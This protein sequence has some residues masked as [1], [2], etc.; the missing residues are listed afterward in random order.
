MVMQLAARD[1]NSEECEALIRRGVPRNCRGVLT[2]THEQM[3]PLFG[4][5]SR[6]RTRSDATERVKKKPR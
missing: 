6:A 4:G 2:R 3:M 5:C 1:L